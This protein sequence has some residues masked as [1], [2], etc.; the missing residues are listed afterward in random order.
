MPAA[1][2]SSPSRRS[3]TKDW[4]RRSTT[5]SPA[6]RRRAK[7]V[8]AHSPPPLKSGGKLQ[9]ESRDRALDPGSP[10]EPVLGPAEG[11]AQVRGPRRLGS[12]RFQIG[13]DLGAVLRRGEAAIG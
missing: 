11:R 13:D 4:A 6:P 10:L 9:R 7:A 1:P 2:R 3:R 12:I 5:V 8:P